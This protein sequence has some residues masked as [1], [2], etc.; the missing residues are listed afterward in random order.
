MAKWRIYVNE[1]AGWE[2]C[3]W[4]PV[5]DTEKEANEFIVGDDEGESWVGCQ[6]RAEVDED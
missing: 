5:F 3:G 6:V 1:G 2:R 4:T